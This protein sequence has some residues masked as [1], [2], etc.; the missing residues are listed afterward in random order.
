M[1]ER[2]P[3][4]AGT[5]LIL[6]GFG[7]M[8]WDL[9]NRDCGLDFG[10]QYLAFGIQCLELFGIQH[11]NLVPNISNGRYYCHRLGIRVPGFRLLG[12]RDQGSEISVLVPPVPLCFRVEGS[13]NMDWDLWNRD[14]GLE[15]GIQYLV[16]GIQCLELFGVQQLEF[17]N[18]YLEWLVPL[19]PLKDWGFRVS[20]I[21]GLGLRQR[22]RCPRTAGIPVF[23]G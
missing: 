8:D 20:G 4:A 12:F 18:S 7:N 5:L 10:I 23:C 14:C 2:C 9:W 6:R 3:R 22:E 1:S 13:G 15:F 17:G 19:P 21:R 16:F 11:M